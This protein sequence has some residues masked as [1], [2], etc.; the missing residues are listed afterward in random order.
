MRLKN[1]LEELRLTGEFKLADLF[2]IIISIIA[3]IILSITITHYASI[4]IMICRL[5]VV[6]SIVF[7]NFCLLKNKKEII[8]SKIENKTLQAKNNNLTEITDN[9]RC[10]KHDF[11][12]IIQAIEGYILVKDMNSLQNY[13]DSLLDECDRINVIDI[14]NGQISDNPAICG[15]LLNKYKLAEKKNVKMNIEILSNLKNYNEKSYL[16]SRM[17]GILLDNA[18]EASSNC[19][20]QKIVNVRFSSGNSKNK[21]IILV[22]NTYDNKNVDTEKI[23]EKNYTTKKGNTGLGLW[24][25]KNILEKDQSFELQTTKDDNLFRQELEI[26]NIEEKVLI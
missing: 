16:I 18:L 10:F 5:V 21:N 23:F 8:G 14:L 25:I 2:C 26:Y 7:S 6:C 19:Y 1:L 12:N 24:K 4:K 17:L 9:V 15:V 20:E 13:L 3:L 22:E 11:N